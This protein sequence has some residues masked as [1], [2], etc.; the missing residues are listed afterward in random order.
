MNDRERFELGVSAASRFELRREIELLEPIQDPEFK[1]SAAGLLTDAYYL[2]GDP[3]R[4]AQILSQF[5]E[6]E[7]FSKYL[8]LKNYREKDPIATRKRAEIF[9]TFFPEP[10]RIENRSRSKLRIGILSPDLREH[11][12]ANFVKPLLNLDRK[13]FLVQVFSTGKPDSTTEKL[14]KSKIAWHDLFEIDSPEI[15]DLIRREKIDILIDLAGH[16]QN[17]RLEIFAYRAAPIQICAIGY[18]ATTG[19]RAMDFFLTDEICGESADSHFTEKLLR[20]KNSH[21]CYSPIKTLPEVKKSPRDFIRFGSFNNVAKLS[22]ELLEAWKKILDRVENS[23]L[24]IKGKICSIE[25]GRSIL[26]A[27]LNRLGLPID[28]IE[29]SPFSRDYLEEY[30]EIDIA[31]DSLPYNGGLTTCESLA[32]GTPVISVR[33]NS[34]GSRFGAS[35]LTNSNLPELVAKDLEEYVEKAIDLAKSPERIK[36]YHATLRSQLFNSKLTDSSRYTQNLEDL[37]KKAWNMF[38]KGEV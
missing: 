12:V 31:L 16:S 34:H 35:I 4:A 29:L 20:M 18:T 2:A 22:D 1:R 19:L 8:F 36:N 38:L 30:R 11:A 32:M 15:F 23:K 14:K 37:L 6:P 5:H 13:N 24:M 27:R 28:R 26:L 33:G 21:L 17:N 7:I 9:Q 10:P 25:D 3:D